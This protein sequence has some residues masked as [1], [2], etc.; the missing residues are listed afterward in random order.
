VKVAVGM[1]RRYLEAIVAVAERIARPSVCGAIR[2]SAGR[3]KVIAG[4]RGII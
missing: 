2:E 1:V 4:A 3:A